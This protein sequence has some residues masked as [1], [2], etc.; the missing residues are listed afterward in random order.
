MPAALR[1]ARANLRAHAAARAVT[2]TTA[3]NVAATVAAAMIAT[4]APTAVMPPLAAMP[5][6][7]HPATTPVTS[8]RAAAVS[9][10]P[11]TWTVPSRVAT[12]ANRAA[13]KIGRAHV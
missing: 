10:V 2:A 9:A 13:A 1:V 4:S 12:G 3:M 11:R 6:V 8:A 5:A 7:Q